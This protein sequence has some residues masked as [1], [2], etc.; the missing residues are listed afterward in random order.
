R[1]ASTTVRSMFSGAA[2]FLSL[3]WFTFACRSA[4]Q[5]PAQ[6]NA[7]PAG[8]TPAQQAAE[9]TS[10]Q[11]DLTLHTNVDEVSLDFVVH[12]KGKKLI[13]DLKPD[14]LSVMDNDTPVKL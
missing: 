3:F 1:S 10:S 12:D 9:P 11:P 13:L 5:S 2:V 4:G 7:P 6:Q 8:V 14:D